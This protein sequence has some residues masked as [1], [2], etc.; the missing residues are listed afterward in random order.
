MRD[1]LQQS[2][3][4]TAVVGV[5]AT[6]DFRRKRDRRL[7]L[8]IYK[9]LTAS[10]V[11]IPT[12]LGFLFDRERLSEI[13]I[14]SANKE[15]GGLVHFLPRTCFE[16]YLLKPDAIANV[17]NEE[18]SEKEKVTSAQVDDWL[19]R[20]GSEKEFFAP[21]AVRPYGTAEWS[22]HVAGADLLYRLFWDLRT[23]SYDKVKHSYR[24]TLY[25]IEHH[26]SEF[27]DLGELLR[28]ILAIEN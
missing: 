28:R 23:I 5:T 8:D 13:E 17:L 10:S 14:Q 12:A 20:V 1:I 25:M 18:F 7:V 6:G 4:G 22:Q 3:V 15:S 27:D 11:L 2:L 21:S 24:L 19:V 16:N 26:R 9:K